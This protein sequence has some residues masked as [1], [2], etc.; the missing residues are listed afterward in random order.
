M[1][2]PHKILGGKVQL[3][4]RPDSAFWWAAASIDGKQRKT[5][6]K[7][8][9]LE[10]AREVA[11]DW[12]L[13]LRGKVRWGDG[14]PKRGKPFKAAV[15]KFLEEAEALT[16]GERHADYLNGHRTRIRLYLMP[17]FGKKGLGEITTGL[18]TEY[19]AKRVTE[20]VDHRTGEQQR[21]AHSTLHKEIVTLRQILK[22]ANAHG[23]IDHLPNLSPP[24]RSSPK[25][26][27]RAWFSQAEYKQLTDAA[28]RRIENPPKPRWKRSCEVLYDF[29]IFM[30]NTGLRPDEAYR[31]EYRD[32]TVVKDAATDERILEIEVRGKRGVG[33]CKS[34]PAAVYPFQ[35]LKKRDNPAPT[36]KV[37]EKFPY[38]LW[39]NV[40]NEE[41]LKTDRDGNARTPYSLRHTYI[42]F[43]LM[44]GADIYQ[45][46]KNCRTSVEMIQKHYAAHLKN[47]LDASA[48][49]VR[50]QPSKTRPREPKPRASEP[51]QDA[52][53]A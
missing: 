43:R 52:H 46:A 21:P 47:T 16:A 6:T 9:S 14:I 12:Y 8:D 20:H 19:R 18:V 27:H 2:A 38:E 51:R 35:R 44:Q 45:I 50:K 3:Y 29:I 23:W 41:R 31:L 5:S 32:V 11:E 33:Y 34:M 24:Y 37:F 10:R 7:Q 17:F 48:I 13:E 42:C 40:L 26:S 53:L 22:T 49:N 25:I 39:K 28:K 15:D 30:A 4:R 1:A 36:D